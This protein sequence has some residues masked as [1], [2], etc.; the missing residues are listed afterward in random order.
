[1]SPS[2]LCPT[3]S[4]VDRVISTFSFDPILEP[5]PQNLHRGWLASHLSRSLER[6]EHLPGGELR[7]SR[8][9][10]EGY[11]D[12]VMNNGPGFRSDIPISELTER[13][14]QAIEESDVSST[15]SV[16]ENADGVRTKANRPLPSPM[17]LRGTSH[18]TPTQE[19]NR[20]RFEGR[21]TKGSRPPHVK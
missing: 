16:A 20:Q 6:H 11:A 12:P 17:G 21:P 5:S 8:M 4:E 1:M 9:P 13:V 2:A 19:S 7:S 14:T 10:H 3:R 15:P 18:P